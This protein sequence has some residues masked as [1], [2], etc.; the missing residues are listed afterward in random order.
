MTAWPTFPK[1]RLSDQIRLYRNYSFFLCLCAAPVASTGRTPQ[2]ENQSPRLGNLP[3]ALDSPQRTGFSASLR[4]FNHLKDIK[5]LAYAPR[6]GQIILRVTLSK[7]L[8]I[9]SPKTV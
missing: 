8:E 2:R 7:N 6:L 9:L 3:T 4:F 1:I 5:L